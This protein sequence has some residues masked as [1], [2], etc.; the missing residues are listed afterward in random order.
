MASS[1]DPAIGPT[2]PSGMPSTTELMTY[3]DE[4]FIDYVAQFRKPNST[5]CFSTSDPESLAPD[6]MPVALSNRLRE[7]LLVLER[8]AYKELMADGAVPAYRDD[9]LVLVSYHDERYRDVLM[10]WKDHD[11]A[12]C[13]PSGCWAVFGTQLSRWREFREWQRGP[14]RIGKTKGRVLDDHYKRVSARLKALFGKKEFEESISPLLEKG[15]KSDV[16]AQDRATNWI[17]YLYY[18]CAKRFDKADSWK[19]VFEDQQR[20]RRQQQQERTGGTGDDN[21]SVRQDVE[22]VDNIKKTERYKRAEREVE[23]GPGRHQWIRDQIPRVRPQMKAYLKSELPSLPTQP[24]SP[25]VQAPAQEQDSDLVVIGS[26]SSLSTVLSSSPVPAR[27]EK[28]G[29]GEETPPVGIVSDSSGL[30][31]A[32]DNDDEEDEDN[33]SEVEG[34]GGEGGEAALASSRRN[35]TH[36]SQKRGRSPSDDDEETSLATRTQARKP[37][38]RVRFEDSNGVEEGGEEEGK[39]EDGNDSSDEDIGDEDEDE[40]DSEEDKESNGSDDESS[41]DSDGDDDFDDTYDYPRA[42]R[43]RHSARLGD[44]AKVKEQEKTSRG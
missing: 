5:Q 10:M 3:S 42:P 7:A 2:S 15:L 22:I 24:L 43:L 16:D 35:L 34:G 37:P 39:E 26:D 44:K 29:V 31:V 19:R 38:K 4:A 32:H 30:S 21:D 18:E 12:Q 41:D 23:L 17:E 27:D 36:R 33:D 8:K 11:G 40:E 25:E 20:W 13:P 9:H 1:G 6:K 28:Y 14:G